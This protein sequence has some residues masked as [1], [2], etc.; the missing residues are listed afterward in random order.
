MG[1]N[2]KSVRR[3]SSI[4]IKLTAIFLHF[5]L[6]NFSS[7]YASLLILGLIL[8]TGLPTKDVTLTTTVQLLSTLILTN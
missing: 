7:F 8:S 4:N 5:M 1:I 2:I 3:G 6:P